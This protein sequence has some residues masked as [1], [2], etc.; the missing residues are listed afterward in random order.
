M[1]NQNIGKI[2]IVQVE[3]PI[4]QKRKLSEK[5]LENLKQGRMIRDELR[6]KRLEEK[7]IQE[8]E[9]QKMIENKIIQKAIQLKK[10]QLKEQAII[11]PESIENNKNIIKENKRIGSK[12][13]I[14]V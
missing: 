13:Y 2:E 6:K 7:E 12:T 11:E 1:E 4:H 9:Y 5:Q 8:K 3:K 10:K 14:F